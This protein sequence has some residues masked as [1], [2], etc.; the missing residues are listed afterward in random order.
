MTKRILTIATSIARLA[1]EHGFLDAPAGNAFTAFTIGE[2]A[3]GTPYQAR[4]LGKTLKHFR[5]EITAEVSG[6]LRE[7]VQLARE[8]VDGLSMVRI[9]RCAP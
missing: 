3:A 4:H 8:R 1:A 7:H 6:L 9:S 5:A 2:I